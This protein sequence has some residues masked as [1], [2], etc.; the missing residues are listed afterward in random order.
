MC[1]EKRSGK[2][3][4]A[5]KTRSAMLYV[6]FRPPFVRPTLSTVLVIATGLVPFSALASGTIFPDV[7]ANHLYREEIEELVGSGI[8]NGNDDGTFAPERS[9]NRAEMLALLYRASGRTPDPTAGNCFPDVSGWYESYVCDAAANRFVQGYPDGNFRP[10]SSVNRAEALKMI[11]GMFGISTVKYGVEQRD[12][13]KF[14]DVSTSAWYSGYLYTAFASGILPIAG[15]EGARFYP[16]WPLMRGEAAAYISNALH[17]ELKQDRASS[18][19]QESSMA[20]A[21][22]S[23]AVASTMS[24]GASAAAISSA[25]PVSQAVL[26]PFT[27]SGKFSGKQTFSYTFTVQSD[28]VALTK[29]QLTGDTGSVSCRLYL[30]GKEGFSTEYYLG[31]QESASCT[32]LTAL[33]AGNYQL[34]LQPTVADASFTV[35]MNTSTGDGNDGF[36][37]S[38]RILPGIGKTVTLMPNNYADYYTFS[39]VNEVSMKVELS[40]V[41]PLKCMV[42]PLD[43]VD[44][45]SFSGPQCNQ[46]Y[47]Y[48]KGTYTVSVSRGA[49]KSAKQTYTIMLR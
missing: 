18:A 19:A 45:A 31:T 28:A 16:E 39:V 13:I 7:P 48:P 6:N 47:L 20:N 36:R 8:I 11:I 24:A 1:E 14:V 5:F 33:R 2:C 21:V 41:S 17:V 43:D 30:L 35:D 12:I 40:N 9:V 25:R 42:N 23:A 29:V 4:I 27:T 34:Q 22:S 32:M 44:L 3:A 38:K 26:F 49:T 15:Q 10:G 46:T 37:E